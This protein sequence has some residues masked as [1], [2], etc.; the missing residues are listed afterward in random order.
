MT[1]LN[2][3]MNDGP[4]EPAATQHAAP[5]DSAGLAA[6]LTDLVSAI[7]TSRCAV[8]FDALG[9]ILTANENFLTLTG[10]RLD[11][12]QGRNHSVLVGDL[13]RASAG[14]AQF[15]HKLAAGQFQSG[16]FMRLGKDGSPVWIHATYNPIINADGKLVKVVKFASDITAAKR[17]A[18]EDDGWIAAINRTQAVIEFDTD[19]II[20]NANERFLSIVG[21]TLQ[22]IVGRHHSIFCA[23]DYVQGEAYQAFWAKLRD[24]EAQAGEF[25]RLD[26]Q[27]QPLWLQ[28]TYT[29]IAGPDG[30]PVRIVKFA[31]DI[32]AA[33]Q[34]ALEDHSWLQAISRSHGVIEFD[35]S[36]NILTANDNFLN[37]MGYSLAELRGRHHSIFVDR[38]EA[39]GAAYRQFWQKL[40][41][42]EFES[43]EYLRL[44]RDN[45]PVWIQATYNPVIDIDGN[46]VKVVKFATDITAARIAS[47]EN[48]VRMAAVSE[49]NCIVEYDAAAKVIDMNPLML[50]ALGYT[51]AEV[52][53]AEDSRFLFDE[54]RTDAGYADRWRALRAGRVASGTIRRRGANDAEAWFSATFSPVMGL[55]GTLAKVFLVCRDVTRSTLEQLDSQGKIGAINRAQAV[56]EFDLDGRVLTANENFLQLMGYRLDEIKGL[57]HRTF[58]DAEYAAS[59]DYRLF[60]ERL[61]RG[62]FNS[63]EYRRI[64][65]DGREVWIQATYNPVL[66]PRGRPVKVVKF[67]S[68]V[69]DF[70]LRNAEF[71]AKVDAISRGQAV[72]EFD[73]EGNVITANRNFL[74]AM[75]YTLR[76]IQGQHHSM[77]CPDAYRQSAEYRDFWLRLGEGEFVSGRFHRV[78]KFNRDV[79]IHATYNP[80]F[81]LSGRVMKVVKYAYD[82]TK[83]VELER[84]IVAKSEAMM[85]SVYALVESIGDIAGCSG[86]ASD[87]ASQ[88]ASAAATGHRAVHQSMEAINRIQA[89]SAKVSEIVRVIGD[90]ANQT[91]LLAFNAAI[92]AARAGQHGVG[93]SV[94]AAEVRKLAERSADAAKEI[95]TLIESSVEQVEQGAD[96]SKSAASSF[97]GIM[98]SVE[99]TA[100]SVRQ[101]AQATEQQRQ[102]ADEVSQLIE[103]LAAEVSR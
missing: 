60:W 66:D 90:I 34:R 85:K 46:M 3:A 88:S 67:A 96:V 87:T 6:E 100:V 28:A 82:V 26:R 5:A 49:S 8:E 12:I 39:A 4:T 41:R 52:I 57:H 86:N 72:I 23:A 27:G 59:A 97:E 20:L 79:H 15:W 93:F 102:M 37:L 56:I 35:M 30:K 64:G 48:A 83:E 7:N 58:V 71:E 9:N 36:G 45:K 69:T 25:M 19:G 44:G 75:G 47:N 10:Y 38:D 40:G 101:I 18:Q 11:E 68:D 1:G 14:Y 21:Y 65:R 55:D 95:S 42:G 91:N 77:F 74:A 76:E 51:R 62:E 99:A 31:T 54:D 43:G 24:G 22:A 81:D 17:K 84:K 103:T 92:E 78:G 89:S 2:T 29:P 80:I 16:E 50:R 13:E 53:G 94:V 98:T 33:K 63:G 61:A 32:T 73:L 70:K